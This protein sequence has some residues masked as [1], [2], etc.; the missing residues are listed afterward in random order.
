[1]WPYAVCK[2]GVNLASVCLYRENFEMM[3]LGLIKPLETIFMI[4]K[5]DSDELGYTGRLNIYHVPYRA[6]WLY[7]TSVYRLTRKEESVLS[8]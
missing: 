7:A 3:G 4:S 2:L 1:M 6:T 8:N 5:Y